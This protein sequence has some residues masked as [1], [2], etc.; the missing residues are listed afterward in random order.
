MEDNF[1]SGP[2]CKAVLTG[3]FAGIVASVSS[4]LYNLLFMYF[5]GFPLSEII[6][7]STIIFGINVLLVIAGVLYFY[8]TNAFRGGVVAFISIFVLLT[9]LCL[10]KITGIQRSENI[11][12]S[13]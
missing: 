6:N 11:T 5:S 12:Y 8:L 10:W 13:I 1:E 7:I 3:L 4:L 9:L 2:F